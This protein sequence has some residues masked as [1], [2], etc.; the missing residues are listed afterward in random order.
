MSLS[1]STLRS[2]QCRHITVLPIADTK[3]V[4]MLLMFQWLQRPA[5]IG[6]T[7]M[8][9]FYFSTEQ[10]PMLVLFALETKKQL[11][12][13]KIKLEITEFMI[14]LFEHT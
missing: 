4:K 6:R 8:N 2:R 11:S 7:V 5:L 9:A 12:E 3:V 10:L 13:S 1:L 14:F